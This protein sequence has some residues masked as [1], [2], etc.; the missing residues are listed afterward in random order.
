MRPPILNAAQVA[1]AKRLY[2]KEDLYLREV[3][4]RLGC[5]ISAANHAVMNKGAYAKYKP[6]TK[7]IDVHSPS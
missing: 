5:S 6:Q 4:E 3:A 1:E 7:L 2:Y